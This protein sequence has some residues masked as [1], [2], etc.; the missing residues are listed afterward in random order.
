MNKMSMGF[1]GAAD[2]GVADGGHGSLSTNQLFAASSVED[3]TSVDSL[4]FINLYARNRCLKGGYILFKS[5][6]I[7]FA[8][9]HMSETKF[10]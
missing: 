1:V 9:L 2:I 8:N 3:A 7:W 4:G 5:F 6:S 10:S